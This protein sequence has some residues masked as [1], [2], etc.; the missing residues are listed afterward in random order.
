MSLWEK[1]DLI[2][3]LLVAALFDLSLWLRELAQA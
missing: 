3:L 2:R 1:L